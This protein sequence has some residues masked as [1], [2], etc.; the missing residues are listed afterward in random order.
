MSPYEPGMQTNTILFRYPFLAL[1][2]SVLGFLIGCG[3]LKF[4]PWAP[5]LVVLDFLLSIVYYIAEYGFFGSRKLDLTEDG[6]M[7]LVDLTIYSLILQYVFRP[8]IKILFE[9]NDNGYIS[10]M[11]VGN[12]GKE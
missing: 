10:G 8:E 9:E 2:L 1:F 7:I 6:L 12:G 3:F 5:G 11:E 4:K